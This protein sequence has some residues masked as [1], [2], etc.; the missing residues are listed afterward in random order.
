LS[1]G[2]YLFGHEKSPG[3]QVFEI[4][5]Y[6]SRLAGLGISLFHLGQD[7]GLSHHHGI[8]AA[9]YSKNVP[10]SVTSLIT[11]KIVL[12]EG[13]LQGV[14]G[15]KKILHRLDDLGLAFLSVGEDFHSI[16]GGYDHS[17]LQIRILL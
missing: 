17:F 15:V 10:Y 12:Q 13:G 4:S 7:L 9:G 6:A 1:R 11:V 3:D 14:I 5:S 8:Q 16:T 2:S